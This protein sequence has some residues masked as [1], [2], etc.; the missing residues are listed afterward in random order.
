MADYSDVAIPITVGV[1][2]W[3]SAMPSIREVRETRF[4]D[5]KARNSLRHTEF[6][7]IATTVIVG[8]LGAYM[9]RHH[10]PLTAAVVVVLGLMAAYEHAL[11]LNP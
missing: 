7:V 10:A 5:E 8:A 2:A 9:C 11:K 6:V 4:A 1:G 3:F